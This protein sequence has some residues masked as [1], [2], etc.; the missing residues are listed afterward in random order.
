MAAAGTFDKSVGKIRPGTYINFTSNDQSLTA[1]GTRGTV[2][3]PLSNTNYGPAGG[4]IK[5]TAKSPDAAKQ[6]LG[7]S[8]YDNDPAGNML[9]IREAL[10][11]ATTIYLYICT[12]GTTASTG[13]GGGL[14]GTAKYKGTRGDA[15]SFSVEANPLSGFDVSVYL[16]GS[17]VEKFEGITAATDISSD[18]ITFTADSTATELSEIAGVSLTGGADGTSSNEDITG[19]LDHLMEISF[20]TIC[21]PFTETELLAAVK[22]KVKYLRENTYKKVQAVV[23]D[24]DADYEGIINVT[25]SYSLESGALTHA[26]ATAYVAGITAGASETESN[27]NKTVEGATGVVDSKE[28]EA[29]QAITNGEFFFS[30]NESGDVVVEYDINSLHTFT[31]EKGKDYRKNKIIRVLDAFANAIYS[32]FPPNK[33]TNDPDGWESMKGVGKALL[34]SFG[35]KSADGSGAIKN[36]DYDNDFLIDEELSTG[37]S[38]YFN[39]RIEPVDAAEKLFFTVTTA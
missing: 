38:T 27:T 13:T 29:E 20:N 24:Y 32:N 11:G 25:N 39:V 16:D 19:C 30:I 6:Y 4:W 1:G 9:L 8:V 3:I 2:V 35:P 37:D 14:V 5:I 36:I 22:T 21:F 33:Y 12:E 7:Y 10:K 31:T 23:P 26:Q 28:D 18:Y 15:L 34:K 17:R